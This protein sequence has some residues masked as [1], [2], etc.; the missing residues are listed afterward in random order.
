MSMKPYDAIV[1]GAR[2]AGSPA[3]MLL[4]RKGYRVLLVDKAKF[5]S[6]TI[7]THVIVPRGA[8]ALERWGL[9]DRVKATGC[10]P[11]HTYTFDFGPLK[12]AGSPGTDDSPNAYCPRRTLLD[13]ILVDA[14][15][16]SG[17]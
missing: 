4:A 12:I 10:P 6:D 1:I 11:I 9:L 17:V 14:A 7:S 8:A 16:E 13:K 5:P 3:A 2:C 15:V